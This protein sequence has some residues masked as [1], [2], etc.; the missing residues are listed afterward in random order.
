M[1][2][3]NFFDLANLIEEIVVLFK[4]MEEPSQ[5]KPESIKKS[6]DL[7]GDSMFTICFGVRKVA[8][9]YSL[10][11]YLGYDVDEFALETTKYRAIFNEYFR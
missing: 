11:N 9:S 3:V 4:T 10:L 5:E 2:N 6:L 8:V 1:G 7:L